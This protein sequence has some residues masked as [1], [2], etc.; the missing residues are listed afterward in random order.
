MRSASSLFAQYGFEKISIGQIMQN[1]DMTHGA[2]YAHFESKEALYAACFIDILKECTG[3]R[4]VKQP[5][6]VSNLL[7]LVNSYWALHLSDS[8][9]QPGPEVVLFNETGNDNVRIRQLFQLSYEYI[10]TMLEKRITALS[11]L[12][13]I[14]LSAET[15]REN[16]RAILA[17]LVGAVTLAKMISD[18]DE[19][20]Q[21]LQT[22]QAQILTLLRQH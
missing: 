16:A 18:E 7:K 22:A 12:Q 13:G 3:S 14:D 4:L 6:S 9:R 1:A 11:R 20:E 2:F 19:R 15:I 8:T 21:L 10:R 5:L 17:S